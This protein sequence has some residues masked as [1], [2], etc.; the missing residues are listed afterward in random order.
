MLKLMKGRVSYLAVFGAVVFLL[1][2]VSSDLY[3][4]TVTSNVIDK[5]IAQNNIGYIWSEGFKM[6][7]VSF[8]GVLAAG[9]NIFFAATQSMKMGQRIRDDMFQKITRFSQEDMDH[10]GAASLDTRTT[11]DVVQIQNVMVQILRMMLMAPL[12]LLGASVMSYVKSPDLT[13][14]FIIC[15]PLVALIVG[16]LMYYVVPLFKTMQKKTD[17]INLIFGEALGGVRTIRS[18]NRDDYENQRFDAANKDF[19]KTGIKA[20]TIVSF[21]IPIIT[22]IFSFINVAIVWFGADMISNRTLAVGNLVAFMTYSGQ[23]LFSFMMLSMIFVFLPRASASAARIIEVLEVKDTI[24][25]P[26]KPQPLGHHEVEPSLEFDNVY[27][28]YSSAEQQTLQNVSFKVRGGQT[29]AIIGGTGSGKSTLINLIPRLIEPEKGMVKV[30]GLEIDKLTQHDL[31]SLISI[32]QQKAVLFSGTVRENML[33]GKRDATDDDIWHALEVAQA[34]EFIT[35]DNGGL[36][37]H[38]DQ[39]GDNF[40]GGQKQRLAIARTILKP[41]DIYIFDDS[42]SALDFETDAKLRMAL[43]T[44]KQIQRAITVIVAQRISTVADADLILVLD[45]CQVVGEG[46]HK[47]LAASNSVYQDILRSQIGEQ[48]GINNANTTS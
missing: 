7:F 27:F 25:D 11:N 41:A 26:D 30:N 48:G 39:N 13:T 6:L 18:F 20:F 28:R 17:R 19:A 47:Q 33:Y 43:R 8:C 1:L 16:G 22:I 36:D 46:S 10:F 35:Q 12:M 37:A 5:G 2:Q 14:I 21:I 38:V 23:I 31:H 42:F 34:T 32:N 44:D 4:P 40:S 15:L 9:G 45:N 24:I 3:L 29:L